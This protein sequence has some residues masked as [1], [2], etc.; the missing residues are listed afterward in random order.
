MQSTFAHQCLCMSQFFMVIK[1]LTYA[2][3][4]DLQGIKAETVLVGT[5]NGDHLT[6]ESICFWNQSH[7]YMQVY[8]VYSWS[9]TA[10][11]ILQWNSCHQSMI[12]MWE[13]CVFKSLIVSARK[14]AMTPPCPPNTVRHSRPATTRLQPPVPGFSQPHS[15]HMLLLIH[16]PCCPCTV[17][18][19]KP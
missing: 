1:E 17:A 15:C 14:T 19:T 16:P 18:T 9:Y 3:R 6:L 12:Y 8:Y 4:S 7:N 5:K 13:V 10:D 2:S 11:G